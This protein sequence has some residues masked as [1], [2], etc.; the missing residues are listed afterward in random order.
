MN[1]KEAAYLVCWD[2]GTG[3][4]W[5]RIEAPSLLALAEAYPELD[6]V[7]MNHLPPWMT[8]ARY[9]VEMESNKLEKMSEPPEPD[10]LLSIIRN[11]REK[12]N[13][14]G[15]DEW[16]VSLVGVGD[17][18]TGSGKWAYMRAPSEWELRRRHPD[19]EVAHGRPPWVKEARDIGTLRK[20][21]VDFEDLGAI[22]SYFE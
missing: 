11:V 10:G 7:T 3:G 9:V 21:V 15:R 13:K 8:E 12:G 2:Y 18:R 19:L 14:L 6:I 20:G 16:P 17:P 22:A 4:I 1:A 5:R